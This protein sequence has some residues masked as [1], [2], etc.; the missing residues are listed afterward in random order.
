MVQGRIIEGR[1]FQFVFPSEEALEMVLRR[2]PWAFADRMLILQCWTPLMNPLMMNFIPFWIQ[3][4]G[5]PFQFLNHN[6]IAHIGRVMGQLMDVDYDANA[7]A[8]VEHMRVRLN[9]NVNEPLRLQKNFQFSPGGNTL[10]RFTYERLRGFCELC[11]MLTHDSGR[12]LIQNGGL[13]NNSD[14]D[15]S[16]DEAGQVPRGINQGVQINEINDARQNRDD[17]EQE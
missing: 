9:W 10:L 15:D 12:C 4:R 2:G 3:I 17:Q 14:G 8:R 16:D 6:V 1:K 13:D 7:A 11:G 5:I